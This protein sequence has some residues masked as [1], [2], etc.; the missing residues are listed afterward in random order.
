M[1]GSPRRAA[2]TAWA[3]KDGPGA[4]ASGAG[5]ATGVDGQAAVR[6]R[7]SAGREH[8]LRLA[9]EGHD[10]L[11]SRPEAGRRQAAGVVVLVLGLLARHDHEQPL[12]L[13]VAEPEL[14][15]DPLRLAGLR[16]RHLHGLGRGAQALGLQELPDADDQALDVE[17]FA[18]DDEGLAGVAGAQEELPASWWTDG[19]DADA[20][21]RVEVYASSHCPESTFLS[22]ARL[23]DPPRRAFRADYPWES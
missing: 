2:S 22:R 7:G 4:I 1:V 11:R 15:H 6:A 13:V 16:R 18:V 23:P 9:R 3:S 20:V 10:L 17:L 19:A 12:A 5:M 14:T 8:P 21:D